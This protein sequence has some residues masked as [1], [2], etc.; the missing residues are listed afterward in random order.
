VGDFDEEMM[1]EMAEIYSLLLARSRLNWRTPDKASQN[2]PTVV[3]HAYKRILLTGQRTGFVAFC[4]FSH[5]VF[6][7]TVQRD[8]HSVF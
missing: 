5:W 1:E 4:C 3:L 8:F 7:G 2:K 6:K